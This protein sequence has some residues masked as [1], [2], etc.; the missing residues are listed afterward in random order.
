LA[1][2]LVDPSTGARDMVMLPITVAGAALDAV[3][4]AIVQGSSIRGRVV[5]DSGGLPPFRP[6]GL[7]V[8]LTPVRSNI[9]MRLPSGGAGTDDWS[10]D[11]QHAAGA[12]R[13]GLQGLPAD[14]MLELVT[15]GG[16]DVTDTPSRSMAAR[17]CGTWKSSSRIGR[18]M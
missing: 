7:R 11:F 1:A 3:V 10:F 2:S 17:T 6:G 13:I 8:S 9:P 4:L 16:R 12:L 5:T 18:R 14:W 15:V